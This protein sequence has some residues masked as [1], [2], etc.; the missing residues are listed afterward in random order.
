MGVLLLVRHGQA[1]IGAAD[2]DRLSTI[3]RRQARLVGG[4]LA[5]AD[6]M[7]QR[8][9]CG[10]SARQRD[11]AVEIVA[12]LG[13]PGSGVQVDARLDE[14][15]HVALMAAHPAPGVAPPTETGPEVP[16]AL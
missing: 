15:D 3:G 11:T 8:V 2:Y 14:F 5:R 16:P 10:T 12:A 1:S 13:V 4:R 9:V 6:L 7:V